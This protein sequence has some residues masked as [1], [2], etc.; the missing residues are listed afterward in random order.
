MSK[1]NEE[2]DISISK[3]GIDKENFQI[4]YSIGDTLINLNFCKRNK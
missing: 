4:R 1:L 2:I 3:Y